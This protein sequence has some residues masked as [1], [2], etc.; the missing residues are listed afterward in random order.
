MDVRVAILTPPSKESDFPVLL[1][2]RID[3]NIPLLC[4]TLHQRYS[5]CVLS[6][7][8]VTYITLIA[9]M[10]NMH[11]IHM[12]IDLIIVYHN[13]CNLYFS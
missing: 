8:T 3:Y 1:T 4:V 9:A 10:I 5:I 11:G 2:K 6:M 7:H 12:T 13:I